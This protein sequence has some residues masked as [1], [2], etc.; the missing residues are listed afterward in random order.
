MNWIPPDF[1]IY[2]T[3]LKIQQVL[4]AIWYRFHTIGD[5]VEHY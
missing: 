3:T 1:H 2:A 4:A 5:S